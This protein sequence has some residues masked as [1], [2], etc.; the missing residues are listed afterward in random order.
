MT[1]Q[2]QSDEVGSFS[3]QGPFTDQVTAGMIAAN[4]ASRGLTVSPLYDPSKDTMN[5]DPHVDPILSPNMLYGTGAANGTWTGSTIFMGDIACNQSFMAATWVDGFIMNDYSGHGVSGLVGLGPPKSSAAPQDQTFVGNLASVMAEPVFTV[6]LQSQGGIFTFGMIDESDYTGDIQYAD[7]VAEDQPYWNISSKS[8]AWSANDA[9]LT[10]SD[11][12]WVLVDTGT[13]L[14]YFGKEDTEQYYKGVATDWNDEQMV[15]DVP[16]GRDPPSLV[17]TFGGGSA[18]IDIPMQSIP[19]AYTNWTTGASETKCMG[20]IQY[21]PAIQSIILL[22]DTFFR[23][24]FVV[25]NASKNANDRYSVG[26]AAK[27]GAS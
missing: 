26:F 1:P 16:C 19:Y 7:I 21:S 3:Q 20:P 4:A 24:T 14:T 13:T 6:D 2:S 23:G 10:A 12:P 9:P 22:G 17:M 11:T 25:Y 5:Y 27:A 8:I 15:Y 18:S